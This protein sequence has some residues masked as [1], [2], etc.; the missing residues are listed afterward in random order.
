MVAVTEDPVSAEVTFPR[1]VLVVSADMGGGHNAT[2]SA[3]EESVRRLWPGSETRRIDALDVMGRGIGPLFRSIYVAN[4]E[5]TPWLYELFYSALW[6]HGWFARASKRFTGSWCGRRLMADIDHFDP[7][8]IV[9]TYPLG[10]AGLAWLRRHRGLAVPVGAWVSDFAPHPFWVYPELDLNLVMHEAAVP[11]AHHAAPG[12][13]VEVSAPPVVESFRPGDRQAARRALGLRPDAFVVLVSCGAYAFGDVEATVTMLTGAGDQVQVVAACG[14]NEVTRR[15]LTQLVLPT[16]RLL[17]L[18]WTDDMSAVVRAS[19]VVLTNAGGAT[20]SEALASGVP[21]VMSSPIA[22]H[23]R[24]NANLMAVT[25]L[26]DV[27][28]S[29]RELANRIRS[30]AADPATLDDLSRR[31]NVHLAAHDF[32]DGLCSLAQRGMSRAATG[33]SARPTRPWPMRAADAFFTHVETDLVRQELGAVVELAPIAPGTSVTALDVC[34]SIQGRTSGL[35]STRRVLVRRL[36]GWLLQDTVEMTRHVAEQA[37][38]AHASDNDVWRVISDFWGKPM[39]PGE[40]AWRMLLVRGQADGRSVLAIKLHHSQGDGISAIGLLDRLLDHAAD[41]PLIERRTSR[42][43][44]AGRVPVRALARGLGHLATRGRVP[45]QP[46]NRAAMTGELDIVSVPLPWSQVRGMAA[47]LGAQPSEVMLGITA[48]ALDRVLRPTGWVVA[49]QPLRAMV[50]I[51]IRAPR[52]DRLFG[53]WTGTIALD[54]PMG[55]MRLAERVLAIRNEVRLRAARGEPEAAELVMRLAGRLPTCLHRQAARIVYTRRFFNT[56]VSYMPGARR[57]RWCA[58]TRVTAVYPVL[59]LAPGVPA[60][61][62]VVVQDGVVGV[63]VLVDRALG[64][65]HDAVAA[66]VRDAFD[67]GGGRMVAAAASWPAHAAPAAEPAQ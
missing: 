67:A 11:V 43:G 10:S 59:P 33:P 44:A 3:L 20:V 37:V 8:L 7:D 49:D 23:G 24:A 5:Q 29:G 28:V 26:A 50:P 60:T 27:C 39:P 18:G 32:D 19:D 21:V 13:V 45:T 30:L 14:R 46:L 62:G 31:A 64:L 63:G 15:R 61:V 4:V 38:P 51:A 16:D 53:N 56:I 52:L 12:A 65:E 54:L 9:S 17:T 22:A 66:A 58:G 36:P 42:S 48:D 41:D 25:G 2:A 55:Q 47:D 35:P 40:P 34:E 57:Q 1:R 6:R